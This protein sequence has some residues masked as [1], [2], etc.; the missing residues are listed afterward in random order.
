MSED[1]ESYIRALRFSWLTRF[2]DPL[3]RA[4]LNEEKFKELL[5]A[6]AGIEPGARVL[7][8]G[9]GTGTLSI[10]VKRAHPSATV[11]ALDADPKIL[12]IA[13][14][15]V[16][17]A[18]VD[19]DLRQGLASSP[20]FD[21]RSFDR[22]LSSLVF[23]HLAADSKRLALIKVMEL[24][25]PGGELH[26]ADW[27]EPQNALMRLLFLSVRFLDGFETTA[28]SVRGR[29]VPMMREA[30]YCGVEET[31]RQMTV[32]GTLS[33]YRALKQAQDPGNGT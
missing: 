21:P 18:G 23:H 6:Q 7:D 20:P 12:R 24:L 33:Y 13:R 19:V 16:A 1:T 2:F 11:V 30:G 8:L 27:G 28:D 10:M 25:R 29:L 26:V 32:F 31:A 9:C 3:L 14:E 4:S 17:R 5:V 22:V 15:K